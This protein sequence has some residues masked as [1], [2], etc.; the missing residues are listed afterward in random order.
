M[1]RTALRIAFTALF[2]ALSAA[3]PGVASAAP[4]APDAIAAAPDGGGYAGSGAALHSGASPAASAAAQPSG[5]PVN[6]IDVSSHDHD[7]G[8]TLNWPTLATQMEFAYV[9]ATEGTSYVNPYFT[10]DSSDAKAAGLYVGAY[11]YGRPDLG[12]PTGQA[13]HF[14]DTMTYEH[15]GRTLPPFLDMEWPYFDSVNTCFNQST[16]AMVSWISSFM[17]RL[18]ARTGVVPMIY[19]NVNWWNQCT[20]N[21]TAFS[22][23]LLDI[24]SC[25]ASPPSA[26]GWGTNW[27]F[28]QYDIPDCTS[29]LAHDSDVYRSSLANL[30]ALAG[31]QVA[32]AAPALVYDNGDGTMAINRWQST[33]SAFTRGPDYTGAYDLSQVGNRVATGDVTGDGVDDLVTA[34]QNGDGTFSFDVFKSGVTPLGTW[35][36][37]GQFN[38][39]NVGGRLVVAD[40]NGDGKAEPAMAYDRGTTMTIFRWK[41]SGSAFTLDTQFNSGAFSLGNVGDRMAAG[42][43]TGD[44]VADIVMAYQLSDGTFAFYVFKS[45]TTSLGQWYKSGQY[46]LTHVA[47]RMVLGDFNGDGKAEPD[48]VYDNGDGTS[49]IYHWT[50]SGS[51]FTHQSN[52]QAVP[53]DPAAVGDRA[54][55]G[56]VDGDGLDDIVTAGQLG[57]GTFTFAVVKGGTSPP[58]QWYSSDPYNLANV[59]GRL[60]LGNWGTA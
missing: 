1:S 25:T 23:Y 16:S 49:K 31:G 57:D 56:D 13:D 33:G 60:V 15:D 50:S 17:T 7:K 54:A 35:Y 27:T 19:T 6:G 21:S 58:E 12:N 10:P 43:V 26:P 53:F 46:S 38:L 29:G 45:G 34:R 40:F 22:H 14:V 48:L 9:K 44:G 11:A 18:Q 2:V 36:T 55:A 52:D 28:W 51:A 20:A 47:G 37:S 39:A 32:K 8:A 59:G 3:L 42:D 41:S 30:A 4:P 24:S 5:Y